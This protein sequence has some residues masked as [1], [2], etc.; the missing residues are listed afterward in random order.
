MR[1]KI[2]LVFF[3]LN[4]F[5]ISSCGKSEKTHNDD[6]KINDNSTKYEE[7]YVEEEDIVSVQEDMS[8]SKEEQ[9]FY[10]VL[11]DN[12]MM[13]NNVIDGHF[14]KTDGDFHDIYTYYAIE[15]FDGDEQ[16]EL[17]TLNEYWLYERFGE[18]ILESEKLRYYEYENGEACL[19]NELGGYEFNNLI[20]YDNGIVYNGYGYWGLDKNYLKEL[21]VMPIT[22][23]SVMFL[24]DFTGM[25]TLGESW[26]MDGSYS[27]YAVEGGG[28]NPIKKISKSEYD[29][30]L[31]K[32]NDG[33][34]VTK[35]VLFSEYDIEDIAAKNGLSLSDYAV[36]SKNESMEIVYT[37]ENGRYIE[38]GRSGDWDYYLYEDGYVKVGVYHGTD[39]NVVI[40]SEIEGHKVVSIDGLVPIGEENSTIVSVQIPDSVV[41]LDSSAFS[42]MSELKN[43][44]LPDGLV[45]IGDSAFNSCSRLESIAIPD[46]VTEIG[47]RAFA[48]CYDLTSITIP[49][50]V[51]VIPYDCFRY[52]KSLTNVEFPDKLNRI[53]QEA[54]YGCSELREVRLPEG[55]TMVGSDAF[56]CARNTVFYVPSSLTYIESGAFGYE[57]NKEDKCEDYCYGQVMYGYA[58]TAS[59]SYAK[60]HG[61]IEFIYR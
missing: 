37:I 38:S 47:S 10:K 52:C 25:I 1:K 13:T 8:L 15:D 24:A 60:D 33:E 44:N 16:L 31:A 26:D 61:K 3:V 20:F 51:T 6:V 2:L 32:L 12:V 34:V 9:A 42:D 23:E 48:G 57:Y 19:A 53:E 18:G 29:D 22:D 41:H 28:V 30:M 56:V 35:A 45:K 55:L 58:G 11:S 54:F 5:V 46:T 39:T 7:E 59:E 50:Q 40:P 49:S 17:I 27:V 36:F 21:G 14:T 43:V 4:A